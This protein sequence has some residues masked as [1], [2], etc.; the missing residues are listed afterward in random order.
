MC[1][2]FAGNKQWVSNASS[3]LGH[4]FHTHYH[5]HTGD[6]SSHVPKPLPDFMSQ[7][8][9][10]IGRRP[11]VKTTLRTGRWWTRSVRNVDSVCTY[12][13]YHFRSLVHVLRLLGRFDSLHRTA[14]AECECNRFLLLKLRLLQ[15]ILF[16]ES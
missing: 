15:G 2:S 3:F 8:W 7:P 1:L 14:G 11:G 13:V 6:S 10:K 12:R 5:V 9:R 16:L 4:T